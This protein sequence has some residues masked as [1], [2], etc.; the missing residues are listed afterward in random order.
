MNLIKQGFIYYLLATVFGG[1]LLMFYIQG[2]S[3]VA[4]MDA[5]G[6]LFFVT[7]CL[8]HAAI[9]LLTLW[10]VFFLPWALLKLRRLAA[11]LL[12]T[13]TSLLMMVGFINMQVYKIYRFH[14]NGFIL[15]MLTGPGA[16]DIF[17]FDWK[18]YLTEALFLAVIVGL[19]IG[20]WWFSGRITKRWK[21]RHT[22]VSILSLVG[23]LLIANGIHVYGSFVVKPSIIK[24]VKLVPY[25]FPLS[26]SN[27]LED[28][29]FERHVMQVD[30]G[31]GG[32]L[33]YPLHAIETDTTKTSRPN[34]VMILIDSWSRLAL[35]EECMP[36]LWKLAHEEQ[37]YQNHV[38]C[39]NGTSFSV[40]GMFTGLQPYYWTAF[41]TSRTSPVL[42]DQ[43]L[44]LGYDFRTYPSATLEDPPFARMLFQHVPNLRIN[45]PG[46]TA[47]ERDMKIKEDLISDLPKLQKSDKPF[48]SFIFFDLL[49]AYSLP[50]ELL[51]RF[52]PSWEYGDFSK[53]HNEM[54]PTPFWNLYR[55]SAYQTDKM[56][57]EVISRLKQLG[58]YDNT[59]IIITGDHAQEYNENHKNYWG[60]NSNFTKYQI[61]VPL[62]IHQPNS[63]KFK[64]ESSKF[65][66]R[67]THLDFV[68]TLMHDYLGVTNPIDDYSNGRL[69]SDTTPRLWH[70]AGNELRYAFIVEGDTILTK[71][72]AGY[73]EVT[74]EHLNP[75]PNYHINPKEFDAAIKRLNRFYK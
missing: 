29:G 5:A 45:T 4:S 26:A 43:L 49:H 17:D 38:S 75:V 1:L 28:M 69:L 48:F 35:T 53:L 59:L 52:K 73:I 13:A 47:Y 22:T 9:L 7:S 2:D 67:T 24:S 62:I 51:N 15:N 8:S 41:E 72:G 34:I 25:Y 58:M 6:W 36:N 16:G 19:C 23:T 10:L 42:V 20:G 14:L 37:W 60:H 64:V 31:E 71:E 61:G 39:G 70:Y 46:N 12:I 54:D 32:D 33:V 30:E 50:K 65:T 57:G 63:S 27:L 11:T 56:V 18:L 40:F 55:N 74:D 21:K 68:P 66:H 44:S 3:V